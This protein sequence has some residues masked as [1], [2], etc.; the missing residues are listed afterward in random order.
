MKEHERF[1]MCALQVIQN[2]H[3]WFKILNSWEINM[4]SRLF[5][6]Q[7]VILPHWFCS[8]VWFFNVCIPGSWGSWLRN[9]IWVTVHGYLL[10]IWKGN[11]VTENRLLEADLALLNS[12]QCQGI[13]KK[14]SLPH[15]APHFHS[16]RVKVPAS[17]CRSACSK[18]AARPSSPGGLCGWGQPAGSTLLGKVRRIPFPPSPE[19]DSVGY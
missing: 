7:M 4:Q 5:C 12:M 18:L 16:C 14:K 10:H 1:R 17:S 2:M 15:S 19:D 6:L 13:K 9:K 8:A 3:L 11:S